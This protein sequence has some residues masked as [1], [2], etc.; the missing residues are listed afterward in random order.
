MDTRFYIPRE[1]SMRLT[2]L[3]FTWAC[4]RD[5]AMQIN[6]GRMLKPHRN[7]LDKDYML[8]EDTGWFKLKELR[9]SFEEHGRNNNWLPR[10][11]RWAPISVITWD[12]AE[13]WLHETYGVDFIKRPEAGA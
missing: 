11:F 2:L 6:Q 3:G 13:T 5:W 8:K 12:Q 1:M 9:K 4:V 10:I 7:P